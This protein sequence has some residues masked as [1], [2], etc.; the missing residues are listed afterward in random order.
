MPAE[1]ITHERIIRA[2]LETAFVNSAGATSLS[3]IAGILGIKKASL[4]NHYASRDAMM[5]D[6]LR[7]CGDYCKRISFIPQ[8]MDSTSAKYTAEAVLK[9]MLHR[10]LKMYEKEPLVLIYSFIESE[11]YFTG[12]AAGIS[13]ENHQKLVEQTC[14]AL[15]SLAQAK[16]IK[17][18]DEDAILVKAKIFASLV[19]D[20]LDGWM[21]QKKEQIR[22]NPQTGEGELFEDENTSESDYTVHDFA[23]EEFVKLL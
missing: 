11:K 21:V 20:I 23:V 4:Y 8:D 9:G 1:K 18:T 12:E 19:T 17:T 3:D 2:V 5:E 10:W 16:K 7:Y 6:T 22:S 13:T 15:K 14:V